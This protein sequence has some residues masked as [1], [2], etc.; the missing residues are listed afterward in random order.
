MKTTVSG[1]IERELSLLSRASDHSRIMERGES[2]VR[3]E[4]FLK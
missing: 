2:S 4:A 3:Q 1:V